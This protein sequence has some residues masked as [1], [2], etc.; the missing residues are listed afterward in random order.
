MKLYHLNPND[1]DNEFFVMAESPEKALE[2]I[3]NHLGY[4]SDGKNIYEDHYQKFKKS[5][6]ECLPDKYSLDD[7]GLGEVIESEIC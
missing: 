6:I 4:L 1:Y 3:V 5:N 7:Y 2:Y